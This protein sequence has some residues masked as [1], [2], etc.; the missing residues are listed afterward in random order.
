MVLFALSLSLQKEIDEST[1]QCEYE[2]AA[3]I[4]EVMSI[5]RNTIKNYNTDIC[6]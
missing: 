4:K 1:S 2:R 3:E 5:I 6:R